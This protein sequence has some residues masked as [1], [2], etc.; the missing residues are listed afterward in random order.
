MTALTSAG[1]S[2]FESGVKAMGT[3][4]SLRIGIVG[5]GSMGLGMAQSMV[6]AGLQVGGFDTSR[7]AV[8]AFGASGG[9]MATS[10]RDAAEAADIVVVVVV[11]AAQSETVLFGEGGA[12]AAMRPGG[13]ILC[14]ATMAPENA[15]RLAGQAEALGLH[16]LDAPVSGGTAKAATGELT[17]MASG[18]REAFAGARAA[19]DAMGSTVY[20]LGEEAGIGASFKMVNQLL[21]GVHIAAACEAMTF[22]A[23]LGLDL[24]KVYEV[25]TAAAGN[26]WMFENRVPHILDA[27]YTPRSA[28]DIFTKDLG[29][30]MDMG[31]SEKFPTQLAATALQM[32]L[33]TAAAGMGRDD[34]SSVARMLADIAGVD[35]PKPASTER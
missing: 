13:T 10:A 34:D 3:D 20:E 11:N 32:Y 26:S 28:I 29:I 16:Y 7:A 31:R 23:R 15:R 24:R 6:A 35:L 2:R 25:I 9:R 30:V 5:L 33:M 22:A 1:K 18:T 19:L 4:T 12:A 21:A 27:D 8:E 14:C 17:F